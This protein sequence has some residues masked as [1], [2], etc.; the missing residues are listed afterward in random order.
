MLQKHIDKLQKL[1]FT[2]DLDSIRPVLE[3]RAYHNTYD[4]FSAAV[5]DRSYAVLNIP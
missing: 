3:M 5:T 1:G 4:T 2:G